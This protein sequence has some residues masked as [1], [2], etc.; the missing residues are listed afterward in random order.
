MSNIVYPECLANF[1][2]GEGKLTVQSGTVYGVPSLIL[3]PAEHVGVPGADASKTE[4]S[5]VDPDVMRRSVVLTFKSEEH[6]D[7][8]QAAFLGVAK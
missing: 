7:A 4:R 6:R 5:A 1:T 3:A 2:F 8:V